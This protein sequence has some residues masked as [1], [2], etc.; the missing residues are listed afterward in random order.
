MKF[1]AT[2]NLYVKLSNKYVQRVIGRKG[3]HF[4]GNGEFETD[5]ELLIKILKQNFEEASEESSWVLIEE[6]HEEP[7]EE[8]SEI[9]ELVEEIPEELSLEEIPELILEEEPKEEIKIEEVKEIE[10]PKFG[11]KRGAK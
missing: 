7:I 2:P 1:K 9:E 6:L 10:K 5:N 11:K 8:I 3:L 4:D